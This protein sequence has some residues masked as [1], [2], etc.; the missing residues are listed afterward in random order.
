MFDDSAKIAV[1]IIEARLATETKCLNPALLLN[2]R[3]IS[4]SM[5]LTGTA[6]VG[7]CLCFV[8]TSNAQ[9]FVEVRS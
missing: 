5:R 8:F 4:A 6:F 2:K 9:S 3:C 7:F 1:A